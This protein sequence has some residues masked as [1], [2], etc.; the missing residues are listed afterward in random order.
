MNKVDNPFIQYIGLQESTTEAVDWQAVT[1]LQGNYTLDKT[2]MP[3]EEITKVY[4]EVTILAQQ[5]LCLCLELKLKVEYIS[6]QAPG[7]LNMLEVRNLVTQKVA[8]GQQE[9]EDYSVVPLQAKVY[10]ENEEAFFYYVKVGI[11]A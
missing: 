4:V 8:E 9:P 11:T 10:L 7:K 1:L 3:I 2:R 6:E 5:G